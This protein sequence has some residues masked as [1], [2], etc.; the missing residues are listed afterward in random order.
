MQPSVVPPA[1]LSRR[2][3]VAAAVLAFLTFV[4]FL[5]TLDCG[6]INFDDKYYVTE[7]KH[8]TNGLTV[9][10]ACWAFTAYVPFYWH[11]LTWLSLQLDASLWWPNPWGFLL[12]NVLLHAA[13]AALVFLALRTLTGAFWRSAAVALLFAVHPLRVESVAWVTERKDVL[14]PAS[15]CWHCALTRSMLIG[16]RLGDTWRWR[17]YTP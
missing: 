13:N 2:D 10:G 15:D 14:M 9:D 16:P 7:N 5:R 3:A 4:V 11:P 1:P 12:T 6:F 17:R 8:V